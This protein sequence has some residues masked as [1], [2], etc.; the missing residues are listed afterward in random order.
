MNVHPALIPAFCGR[1]WYGH[2]VHEAVIESGVKLTGCTVHLVDDEYDHG[3]I[4]IQRPVEVAPDDTPE[5]LAEKVQAEERTAYPEAIRLYA[6][7][8]LKVEGRKVR[9]LPG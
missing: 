8:R 7:G 3:P 9:V 2:H 5:T 6:E 1:G 4:I